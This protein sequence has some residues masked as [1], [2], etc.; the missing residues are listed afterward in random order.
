MKLT[1]PREPRLRSAIKGITWRMIGTIDTLILSWLF[2]GSL[3][4]A[5]AIGGTEIFT[6]I[7]LFYGHER[8]WQRIP[9]DA[10]NWFGRLFGQ[11][12]DKES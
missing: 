11:K 7:I 2:T 6:K 5:A 1:P 9:D 8:I 12:P 4:I 3:S 10:V